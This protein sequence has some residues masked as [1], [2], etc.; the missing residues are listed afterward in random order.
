MVSNLTEKLR[1]FRLN[2]KIYNLQRFYIK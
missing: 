1:D 2:I